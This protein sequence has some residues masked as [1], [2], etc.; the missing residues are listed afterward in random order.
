M[1]DF[2]VVI[3]AHNESENLKIL[4]PKLKNALSSLNCELV[5]VDNASTDDS[6]KVLEEFQKTA[7]NLVIVYEPKLGYGNAILAGLAAARGDFF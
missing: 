1:T 2:S 3:P 6:R 7:P 5:I 4:L